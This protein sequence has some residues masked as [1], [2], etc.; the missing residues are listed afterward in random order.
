METTV[1]DNKL[2]ER[3]LKLSARLL[4][5]LFGKKT[6]IFLG[7]KKYL[8]SACK[9]FELP[10]DDYKILEDENNNI[11]AERLISF[12][13]RYA[14]HIFFTDAYA[15]LK[16]FLEENNWQECVDFADGRGL[17]FAVAD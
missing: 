1:P 16:S 9:L 10:R 4:M 17:L 13:R 14:I 3:L 11:D 6:P 12:S 15:E 2:R 8:E 7:E 5:P